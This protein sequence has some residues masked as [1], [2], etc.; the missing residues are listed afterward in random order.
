MTRQ[1][2]E[3]QEAVA[4]SIAYF[5]GDELAGKTAIDKY[6]LKDNEGNIYELSPKDMHKRYA[7]EFHRM[8][9]KYPNPIPLNE[10]QVLFDGYK[11]VIPGG[12]GMA[13]IGNDFQVTSLSN[14]FVIGNKSDSYGGI[15]RTDEQ[16][17]QLMKRR[18]GVGQ[19][20]SHLRPKGL[21]VKNSAL[22]STGVVPYME[23]Y[24]N[25]TKEVAQDGRR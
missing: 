21:P 4:A 19:D 7:Q 6:A 24:S 14:C 16:Q 2:V 15:Y 17:V 3:R 25:S 8:E 1:R 22:T 9:Q 20:L 5:N 12:G 18:G 23:R 13:G 11:Y 10:I